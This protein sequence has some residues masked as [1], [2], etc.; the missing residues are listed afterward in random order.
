MIPRALEASF[1]DAFVQQSKYLSSHLKVQ[2]F[3]FLKYDK[4]DQFPVPRW[5]GAEKSRSYCLSDSL[6][7]VRVRVYD[8]RSRYGAGPVASG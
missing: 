3:D 1:I 7:R 6:V 5:I 8:A 4:A 2:Q